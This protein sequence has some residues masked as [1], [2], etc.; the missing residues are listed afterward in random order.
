MGLRGRRGRRSRSRALGRSNRTCC[1][2]QQQALDRYADA[3]VLPGED[4]RFPSAAPC[5]WRD[6]PRAP[7]AGAGDG[8]AH[9]S[10]SRRSGAADLREGNEERRPRPNGDA[11][12][13][14][15]RLSCVARLAE[16]EDHGRRDA[17]REAPIA[18]WRPATPTTGPHG[19]PT[20]SAK[21]AS[22]PPVSRD[23]QGAGN[24]R[25]RP[26]R[27]PDRQGIS[28]HIPTDPQV[29]RDHRGHRGEL[30]DAD[31]GGGAVHEAVPPGWPPTTARPGHVRDRGQDGAGGRHRVGNRQGWSAGQQHPG[32]PGRSP[33]APPG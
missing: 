27:C 30:T 13:L 28:R 20:G 2:C 12:S 29:Q 3:A 21:S 9:A 31:T 11:E 16:P 15:I 19:A 33:R 14:A 1:G 18:P 17:G 6:S 22:A 8:S 26:G 7:Q 24:H 10:A 23:H 4:T 32:L 25:P 5:D